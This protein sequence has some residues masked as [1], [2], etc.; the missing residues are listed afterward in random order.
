MATPNVVEALDPRVR[1]TRRSL[2]E[3]LAALLER[4]DFENISVQD[5]AEKADVNRATFYAHYGDKYALLESL[6]ETRF[7]RLIE[8]RGIVFDGCESALSAIVLGVCDFLAS[9]PRLECA[10][11]RQIEPHLESAVIRLVSRTLRRGLDEHPLGPTASTELIAAAASWAIFGAA[12][13]WVLTPGRG[14]SEA[15]SREIVA[16]V[17]PM[18]ATIA[19]ANAAGEAAVSTR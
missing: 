14:S 8:E 11:Q 17:Q 1:R 3:A 5:I 2:Q 19:L 18:L 9:T 15:V 6:V 12:K 13:H 7:E 10:R 16:V 4:A